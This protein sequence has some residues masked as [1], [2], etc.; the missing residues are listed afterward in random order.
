MAATFQITKISED[1]KFPGRPVLYF[2][3][4]LDLGGGGNQSIMNGIVRVMDD[5]EDGQE[6][7]RWS[8]VSGES[9]N[10]I[11]S[12]EGVQIG[13]IRSTYGVLGSWTTVFHDIDDPVGPFWL[14]RRHDSD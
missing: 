5:G 9:G 11:W 6:V 14:R 1:P 3:G 10:P 13:G 4:Q 8:F 2:G 7:V 12:G